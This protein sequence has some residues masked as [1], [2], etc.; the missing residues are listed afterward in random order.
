MDFIE[1]SG[2]H[3]DILS[4]RKYILTDIGIGDLFDF[5]EKVFSEMNAARK[6]ND[7]FFFGMFNDALENSDYHN[8]PI[9]KKESPEIKPYT[10][11]DYLDDPD[12]M[13]SELYN[14]EG[15]IYFA[16]DA[17]NYDGIVPQRA[18]YVVPYGFIARI[19]EEMLR[20]KLSQQ[21]KLSIGTD[22]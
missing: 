2:L 11:G 15:T 4:G 14:A 19:G 13:Y 17:V 20:V 16:C 9:G 3:W 8:R 1:K 21:R 6:T 22:T 12:S 7:T 18:G 5:S 10:Y